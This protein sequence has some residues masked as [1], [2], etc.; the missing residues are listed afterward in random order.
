MNP[1]PG[2]VHINAALTNISVAYAVQQQNF[3]AGQVFPNVPVQYQSNSYWIYSREDWFRTD[4]QLRAPATETPGGGWR[5][6]TS[7]YF[8]D[9]Y[10][11]HKDVDDQTRANCDPAINLD[12]DATT[13]VTTQLLLKRDAL[14]A[15]KFFTTGIWVGGTAAGDLTGV[16]SSPN[17][18]QFVKW[19]VVGSTPIEDLRKQIVGV[20][21]T[22]GYTPNVLVMG[23]EVWKSL[24]DHAELLDRIKYT[25]RGMI[26]TDLLA[27]LL[28]LDKVLVAYGISNTAAEGQTGSYSF[29]FGKAALLCYSPPNPGLMQPAAGY[30]FSWTGYLGAGGQGQRIKNFRQEAIASDRVEGEMAFDMKTISTDL[31]VFFTAAVS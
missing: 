11:I 30:T 17:S 20:A 29:Q 26:G 7:T 3:I 1:T 14:W 19:D 25:E 22:T 28:G 9:I 15:S 18:S 10:G 23:A 8:A 21:G 16:A 27:S 4:V 12:R 31:G 24:A 13:Y 2:D 5:L 6:T